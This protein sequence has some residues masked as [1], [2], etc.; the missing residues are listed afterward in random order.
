MSET[1]QYSAEVDIYLDLG[2]E[3]LIIDSFLDNKILLRTPRELPP[4]S[5]DLVIV[6]DGKE[7]RRK[8]S[9]P[10]GLRAVEGFTEYDI[11]A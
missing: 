1:L 11:A 10:F 2:T 3:K 5:A 4:F 6:V 8:V 7:W 9:F